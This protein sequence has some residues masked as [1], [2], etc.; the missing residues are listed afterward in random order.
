M[1]WTAARNSLA[2]VA[3][4]VPLRVL[5]ALALALLL[6][7]R[8]RGVAVYRAA[9]Y[10]PSVIPSVA[11]AL[12]WAWIFNPIYGPIN[13]VLGAIGLPTPAWLAQQDAWSSTS[14]RHCGRTTSRRRSDL[15]PNPLSSR[16]RGLGVRS[17]CPSRR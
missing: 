6:R 8:R 16:E 2:F 10:L 11:Y 15:N 3:I 7:Q 14:S 13:M 12:I 9:V 1:F 4:A 17:S 5:G